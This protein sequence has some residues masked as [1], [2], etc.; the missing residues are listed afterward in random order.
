[1]EATWYENSIE[2]QVRLKFLACKNNQCFLF[3]SHSKNEQSL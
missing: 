1:M 3:D 2:F